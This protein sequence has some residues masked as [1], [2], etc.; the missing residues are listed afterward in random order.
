V[1]LAGGDLTTRQETDGG[2]VVRARLPI[3]ADVS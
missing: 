1:L 3:R 2:F